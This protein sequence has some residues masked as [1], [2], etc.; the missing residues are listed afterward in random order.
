MNL[1]VVFG[2]VYFFFFKQRTAYEMRISDWSSDVCSS[3]LSESTR[4]LI[5]GLHQN[6]PILKGVKDIW[7]SSDVYGIV[8]LPNTAEILVQGLSLGGMT[9]DRKSVV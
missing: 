6:H 3:D 2:G 4:G 9:Q 5:E 1:V 7:G 8:H